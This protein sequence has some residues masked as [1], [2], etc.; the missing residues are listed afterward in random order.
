MAR[1]YVTIA[2]GR[3]ALVAAVLTATAVAGP[4]TGWQ[5][6]PR[7]HS[8][9]AAQPVAVFGSD[10]RVPTPAK[11]KDVQE[12]IG[13]FFNLRRRTVC[14]AFC[15]APDVIA[16]AGHCLLGTAG[17]RPAR[18]ADFWFARNYDVVR[19]HARIAGHAN[20]TATQH[21]MVGSASLSIRP[22][23]DA[24]RDWALVRL[25]RP[26][27]SKGVLP[28]RVLPIERV[29][30]E[31]A[32]Q[33]VFQIA[34]HRD[35]IPWK[36][37]YSRPCG[38]AKSFGTVDWKQI[39]RDFAEP[40]ALLLHTC[41]TGGASSGSPILL[42]A[43]DGPEVIGINVGTYQQ[44]KV[45]MQD[46]EVKKRL[47]ADT[48]ANTGVASAAF[49]GKLEAFRQ[50]MILATPAEM[51]ELQGLL[52]QRQLYS[53]PVDGNYGAELKTA[54]ETYEKA[55]G[56]TVTGLATVALLQRLGGGLAAER[57]KARRGKT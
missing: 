4:A 52:A 33:R 47:K 13:L 34:Y 8:G 56:L 23:I 28:V 14:T 54:I 31:A 46:G 15:V 1:A 49:A 7:Q 55:E 19:E 10:D 24:T 53:G 20:G 18:F 42:D 32:A 17:E 25:A 21:V 9:S 50:A 36:P 22:P 29:L 27:C 51:R 43:P 44:S 12:K 48:I 41:D 30:S 2:R 5:P 40:D 26:A 35:Y 57:G 45:L 6:A 3:T 11:Y 37:A 16:T 39:A 38:V